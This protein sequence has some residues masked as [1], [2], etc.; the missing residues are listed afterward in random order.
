MPETKPVPLMELKTLC[1][2]KGPQFVVHSVSMVLELGPADPDQIPIPDLD[3]LQIFP[4]NPSV[5]WVFSDLFFNGGLY[6]VCP[7]LALKCQVQVAAD[8][9]YRFYAGF[10][11]EFTVMKYTADD[12][13]VKAFDLAAKP[14]DTMPSSRSTR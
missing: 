1:P 13:P 6:D 12:R 3:S 4:W 11:P 7:R 5:A 14:T 2:R 10:E 9:G 8:A